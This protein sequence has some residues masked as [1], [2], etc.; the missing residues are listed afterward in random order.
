MSL[1]L[2]DVIKSVGLMELALAARK[3]SGHPLLQSS[4]PLTLFNIFS[5]LK[6]VKSVNMS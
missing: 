5:S 2:S 6:I 4:S 3:D 1:I